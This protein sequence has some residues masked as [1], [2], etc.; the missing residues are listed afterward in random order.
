MR[1][2][3][4]FT[5]VLPCSYAVI[6]LLYFSI[7]FF[8]VFSAQRFDYDVSCCGFLM[9]HSASGIYRIMSFAKYGKFSAIIYVCTFFSPVL[10]HLSF[11]T[12]LQLIQNVEGVCGSWLMLGSGGNSGPHMISS[13]TTDDGF[14]YHPVGLKFQLPTQP[15]LSV[16]DWNTLVGKLRNLVTAWREWKSRLP[17]QLFLEWGGMGP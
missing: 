7:L 13:D 1:N 17:S 5:S 12:G 4:S 11:L 8:L 10:F 6:S 3:L 16:E 15:L 14:H 2:P 9:V